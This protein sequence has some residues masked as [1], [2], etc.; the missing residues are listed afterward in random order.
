MTVIGMSLWKVRGTGSKNAIRTARAAAARRSGKTAGLR[1]RDRRVHSR[2]SCSFS[3]Q[4]VVERADMFRG[5]KTPQKL[6]PFA[7]VGV[8]HRGCEEAEAKGH[9][10][11]VQHELL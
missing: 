2:R 3:Q 5:A 11:D 10:E 9:H 1:R 8:A 6:K 7:G 4:R